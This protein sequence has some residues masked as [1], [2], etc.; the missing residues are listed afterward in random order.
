[1]RLFDCR[2]KEVINIC[3]CRKL[4]FVSDIEF[5]PD[6]GKITALIVPGPMKL[7]SSRCHEGEI[8]IPFCCV[9]QFGKEIILVEINPKELPD[10]KGG[11][12]MCK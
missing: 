8:V 1:M 7:F 5:C 12:E 6:T 11:K 10:D 9:R 2:N 3:D 4:G